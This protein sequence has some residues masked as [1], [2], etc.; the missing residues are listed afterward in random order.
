VKPVV[1][2]VLFVCCTA[3][4]AQSQTFDGY[5][6]AL[7]DVLP[8]ARLEGTDKHSVTELRLRLFGE[9]RQD[10]GDRVRLTAAGFA[11]GLVADRGQ[12]SVTRAAIVRPQD[13][14]VEARWAHA[15]VRV[16]FS[17]VVWG[18]LDEFLPTD[19]I[20]PLDLT[21]FFLEGRSEARMPV[22]MIRTRWLPSD[23]FALEAIYVPFFRRGEFDQLDEDTAPFNI[24]PPVP[25]ARVEPVRSLSN[26][27]G[28]V[29]A[30]ATT[31]RIDWA[32]SAYRGFEPL[33]VY[34]LPPPAL[35]SLPAPPAPPA[36]R[37]TYPRFT[38]VGG[39]FETVRGQ[40]GVRGEI[41]TFL[42][43][44]LQVPNAL[45][46]TEGRS[47]DAG[48]GVDRRAG[49][50]RVS[51]TAMLTK[52]PDRHDFTI[53]SSVDRSFARETRTVRAFAV[54]NP[55]EQSV[56]ARVIASVSVRDNVSVEGST[57]WFEGSGN[58]ALARFADR[59][60]FYARLKVFF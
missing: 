17:R 37:A 9:Y 54:Y 43:R 22:G 55:A 13:V 42:D 41:A 33:P 18:R 21:R 19:V 31:G 20:N 34:V 30:S 48:F 35:P 57:G 45:A 28:G 58:D 36:L 52:R 50:Y 27:Q 49:S 51:G 14:N 26:A 24:G 5:A 40:W 38:M 6:A 32:I 56:F 53:V 23:R 1:L 25:V 8:S 59:D 11:E 47:I 60:F 16:G 2:A 46:A 39:D 29:R 3:R 7:A 10:L 44:T 4:T 15:D 12:P